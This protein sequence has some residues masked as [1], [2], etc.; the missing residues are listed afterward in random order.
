MKRVVSLAFVLAV[1]SGA[2]A[3]TGVTFTSA[4]DTAPDNVGTVYAATYSVADNKF[5]ASN[6]GTAIRIYNGNTGAYESDLNISGI[7]VSGLGFFALTS[8]S[9]GSIFAFAD[10]TAELWQWDN[11][12]DAT[13]ALAASAVPFSRSGHVVGTGSGTKVALTGATDNGSI[14]VFNTGDDITYALNETIDA[15]ALP[16]KSSFAINNAIDKGWAVGDTASPIG[17]AAKVAGVWTADALFVPPAGALAAAAEVYD[18]VNNVLFAFQ[19]TTIFALHGDTGVELGQFAVAN[20]G[21]NA[22]PGYSGAIVSSTPGAGT[23]W[24]VGRGATPTQA[25]LEKLTYTVTGAISS[26]TDWS[27]Y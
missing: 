16:S 19:T 23:L 18:N 22:T 25:C 20:G 9:D 7:T 14:V 12:A 2:Y 24:M 11:I 17:R 8:G 10:T 13:P 26:V 3:Q 5:L 21:I 1:A 4:L 27:L 15:T 6:A